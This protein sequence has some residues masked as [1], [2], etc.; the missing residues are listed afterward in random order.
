MSNLSR[1]AFF[2]SA[3]VIGVTSSIFPATLFAASEA[4]AEI[5]I[6]TIKAAEVLSGLSFTDAERELMLAGLQGAVED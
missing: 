1:R 4:G 2:E 3:A 6:D 5:T